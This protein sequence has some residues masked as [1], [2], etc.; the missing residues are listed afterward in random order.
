METG[1][2]K[3]N[4]NIADILRYAPKML[5]LFSPI[6]GEVYFDY[7]TAHARA[8]HVRGTARDIRTAM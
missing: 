1:N 7:V 6:Y 5:E 3:Q 8:V 4:V 2:E